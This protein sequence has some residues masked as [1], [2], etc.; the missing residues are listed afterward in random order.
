MTPVDRDN[1]FFRTQDPQLLAPFCGWGTLV[2]RLRHGR[3]AVA[4]RPLLQLLVGTGG[5]C[6]VQLGARRS[7]RETTLPFHKC[8]LPG[9]RH[10]RIRS[11]VRRCSSC[12][13][14]CVSS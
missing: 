12:C 4:S 11:I 2:R 14:F 7:P 1:A 10:F 5:V 9:Q 6:A 3:H 13:A 8:K